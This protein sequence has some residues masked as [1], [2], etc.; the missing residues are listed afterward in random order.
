[1]RGIA[2]RPSG[3]RQ[4]RHIGISALERVRVI[5]GFR[6]T[7]RAHPLGELLSP[8]TPDTNTEVF[9]SRR[10]RVEDNGVLIAGV[11][12]KARQTTEQT[13]LSKKAFATEGKCGHVGISQRSG[14]R[15]APP[16]IARRL[17]Q[18]RAAIKSIS[19]RKTFSPCGRHT[20]GGGTWDCED[21]VNHTACARRQMSTRRT[22]IAQFCARSHAALVFLLATHMFQSAD[23]P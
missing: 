15:A 10:P 3:A 9:V 22:T 20:L 16:E 21:D 6:M 13:T 7:C 5:C 4:P 1:M 23:V 8:P 17:G 14:G 12:S 11:P 2:H 19:L 18:H